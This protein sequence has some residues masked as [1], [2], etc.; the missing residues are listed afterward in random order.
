MI[1]TFPT[2]YS[3]E[4]LYNIIA[5]LFERMRYSSTRDIG[6]DVF[7][8]TTATAV[9]DLPHRLAQLSDLLPPEF[10]ISPDSLITDNTLWPYWAAFHCPER[11]EKSRAEMQSVGHPYLVL[12]LMASRSPWPRFFRYCPTCVASD[13]GSPA[14]ETYWHRVHQ[15]PGIDACAPHE[16]FLEDSSVEFRQPR[17]R[18]EYRSAEASIPKSTKSQ[19]ANWKLNR[20]ITKTEIY[21][22]RNAEWLLSHSAS[23]L[24]GS[25]LRQQYLWEFAKRGLAT[26]G[27]NLRVE[28]LRTEF[29]G[30]YSQDWLRAIGCGIS[31]D[32]QESWLERLIHRPNI[33]HSTLKHL[34]LLDFLEIPIESF[35]CS[36]MPNP[37]G[38]GPWPCLNRA[39]DHFRKLTIHVCDIESTRNGASLRGTFACPE[40]GMTYA[41]LGPDTKDDD[42]YCRD[43]V[44]VFGPVWKD[45]LK[46]GWND[47]K[48]SLRRLAR[49]LGV[50]TNT[51]VGEAARLHLSESARHIPNAVKRRLTS[52]L[53]SGPNRSVDEYQKEWLKV[54][55]S[56]PGVTRTE[57][58]SKALKI[59]TFLRRHAPQWLETNS[60]PEK[61]NT[62]VVSHVDWDERDKAISPEI[63]GAAERLFDREPL[64]RLTRT[65]IL[66]EAGLVWA[67]AKLSRLPET[68]AQLSRWEETWINFAIRRIECA[69][70]RFSPA[71]EWK[72]IRAANLRPDL[73][74]D[75]AVAAA[76][77]RVL[78]PF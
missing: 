2:P 50:D 10:E 61:I 66:R 55:A 48:V 58:R 65:A 35:I 11:R 27:G 22:A 44:P 42:R 72:L 77:K 69:S 46:R 78:S 29:L 41:R 62:I 4:L 70:T 8:A 49:E 76:L 75:P 45:A 53:Q 6:E 25:T 43:R 32:E 63:P 52:A 68:D 34:L 14:R 51:V 39:A 15:I 73:V 1:G 13:R 31:P 26:W 74:S 5:R 57:L 67:L 28:K 12:G 33:A 17:N 7:Q 38:S 21:L 59:Y 23:S 54:V 71:E 19:P 24:S 47:P 40:C 16:C 3:D 18:F 56:N 30:R 9:A 64:V 20:R 37:F 36:E 60:P